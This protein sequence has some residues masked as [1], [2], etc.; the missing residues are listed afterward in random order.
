MNSINV[1]RLTAIALALVLV[2]AVVMGVAIWTSSDF[3]I[4]RHAEVLA[5]ETAR[6]SSVRMAVVAPQASA[7]VAPPPF[8]IAACHRQAGGRP[9]SDD[10]GEDAVKA[11]VLG[12]GTLYGLDASQKRDERYRDAY[13]RCM[14]SRGF[15]G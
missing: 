8:I 12:Q 13:A 3:E 1:W 6:S 7:M 10:T 2:T 5:F 11:G 4:Q 14:R 15:S 9:A